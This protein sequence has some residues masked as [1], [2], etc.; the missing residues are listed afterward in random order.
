MTI[1]LTRTTL[2]VL[3]ILVAAE[4]RVC[5]AD[6]GR[7]SGIGSGARY[8]ILQRLEQAG[9]LE[10]MWEDGDPRALGRPRRRYYRLSPTGRE[11]AIAAVAARCIA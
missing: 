9:W 2:L 4:G 3:H 10:S 8:T 1:R 5:G 11:R 7:R 6:I